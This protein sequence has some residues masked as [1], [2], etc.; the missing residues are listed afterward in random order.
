MV[1]TARYRDLQRIAV[2]HGFR[3]ASMS[4][5]MAAMM[6]VIDQPSYKNAEEMIDK[7]TSKQ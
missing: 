6:N 3:A 4:E 5:I 1:T 2:K 7:A